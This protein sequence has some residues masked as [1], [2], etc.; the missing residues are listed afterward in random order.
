MSPR[1][2]KQFEEIRETR[3]K[4]I[5]EAALEL[6]ANEGFYATSISKIAANAGISK[7][8]LYNYFESKED[9]IKTIIFNGLDNL[10]RFV[11]PNKDGF[12]TKKELKYFLEEMFKA[13]KNEP[14]FWKLYFTVF[15]Q[16]QVLKLVEKKLAV[17]VHKYLMMLSEYFTSNGSKDPETDA[18]FFGALLD[19]IGFQFMVDPERFPLEKVKN[20]LIDMYCK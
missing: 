19:G 1:T 12:L 11:D 16:P 14:Y 7:G 5:L 6:F 2:E 18:L 9:L 17:M 20:K 4:E 3:K 8:L 13:L 15:M 10:T